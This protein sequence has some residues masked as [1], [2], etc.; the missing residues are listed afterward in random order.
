[1]T[2]TPPSEVLF[3]IPAETQS[4]PSL[5]SNEMNDATETSTSTVLNRV[6]SFLR[7][8]IRGFATIVQATTTATSSVVDEVITTQPEDVSSVR[9]D[10]VSEEDDGQNITNATTSPTEPSTQE[11]V[12]TDDVVEEPIADT[13][14]E[15]GG[16]DEASTS[17][18]IA[19]QVDDDISTSTTPVSTT[20]NANIP[21]LDTAGPEDGFILTDNLLQD[22]TVADSFVGCTENCEPHVITLNNFAH[23]LEEGVE[24]SGAQLRVSMAAEKKMTRDRVP[25]VSIQYS[26]DGGASWSSAGSVLIEEEISNSING[27]YFLFAMPQVVDQ[28]TLNN[29][30]VQIRYDD[31]MNIV[32]NLFVES[33]WVELFTLERPSE[34]PDTDIA[35]LLADDGYREGI[36]SGDVLTLPDG[37]Q[38]EFTFTDNNDD[39][40]LII[41]SDEVTYDGLTE[42][43]T[44]FSVTN[45][46]D[47]PDRFRV[48]A[49]FPDGVGTVNSLEM[50]NQNRPRDVII[51]EYRP[52]VY[53]CN[54]GWSAVET[55]PDDLATLSQTLGTD[56]TSSSNETA[57]Y[58][59]ELI[60]EANSLNLGATTSMA[61]ATSEGAIDADL[62][63]SVDTLLARDTTQSVSTDTNEQ[64]SF[65]CADTSVIQQCDAIEADGTACIKD[66]VLVEE[67]AV[68]Q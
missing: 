34:V 20:T 37:E 40:T 68:V 6:N 11:V 53:H 32:Q 51:P 9:E 67:H 21:Q 33:A 25:A 12:N 42:A 8:A 30:S 2:T 4:E 48:N 3:D 19:N 44:Y 28:D 41:K 17:T 54:A 62:I 57:A 1:M 15:T 27:G 35:D 45:T 64:S 23:P 39:E 16:S 22:E 60:T 31:D 56:A 26:V 14:V 55:V 49:Y 29:L 5:D 47:R 10:I 24:I 65:S 66:Q 18:D 38:I 7:L 50:Y 52:Y 61:T 46:T 36:L 58:V 63:A 13:T 59:D 43:V